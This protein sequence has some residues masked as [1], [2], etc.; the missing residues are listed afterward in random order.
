MNVEDLN[1]I[2]QLEHFLEGTQAVAFEVISGKDERYQWIQR[3]LI[4][5]QHLTLGK[6]DRGA[7]IRF[8]GKVT[9]YSRQQLTRLIK[10][11]RDKG[12]LVR[13]QKT[14]NGFKKRYS[15]EDINLLAKLDERHGTLNGVTGDLKVYRSWR[16][17][18]VFIILPLFLFLQRLVH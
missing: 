2:E 17:E 1:S 9:G 8:L 3:K 15:P 11:Y 12:E 13:K 10:Q 14:V 4:K 6:R 7:V 16:F 18:N 5:F